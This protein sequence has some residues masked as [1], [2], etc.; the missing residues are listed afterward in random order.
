M[1][2]YRSLWLEAVKKKDKINMLYNH[3]N[4]HKSD[5]D[6]I[7]EKVEDYR[8]KKY[9]HSIYSTIGVICVYNLA[10]K[11]RWYFYN[12][13]NKQSWTRFA[14]ARKLK[15]I[16]LLYLTYVGNLQLFSYTYDKSLELDLKEKGMFDKYNIEFFFNKGVE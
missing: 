2:E 1:Q 11:N 16:S 12:A 7:E 15:K 10:F 13:L 6:Y 14:I 5:Y 8:S 3:P 9:L 4:L